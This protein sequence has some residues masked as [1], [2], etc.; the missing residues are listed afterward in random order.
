[1]LSLLFSLRDCFRARARVE[2]SKTGPLL[3]SDYSDEQEQEA[4]WL[5]G[6]MLLPRQG[7]VRFRSARQATEEIATYYGVS[8]AWCE[9]QLRMTGVDSQ[10]RRAHR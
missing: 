9:W 4:D 6:A 10:M 5:A 8:V 7:L 3:L 1:M 2:V